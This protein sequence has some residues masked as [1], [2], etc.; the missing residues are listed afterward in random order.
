MWKR[1]FCNLLRSIEDLFSEL[2]DSIMDLEDESKKEI[3]DRKN[4]DE[5]IDAI[6]AQRETCGIIE[7]YLREDEII[8]ILKKIRNSCSAMENSFLA[9]PD[10]RGKPSMESPDQLQK[11]SEG[12]E[13]LP[14]D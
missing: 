5:I 13:N 4:I 14:S 8:K 11:D 3:L 7:D 1:T 2:N 10:E 9:V 6:E 12:L